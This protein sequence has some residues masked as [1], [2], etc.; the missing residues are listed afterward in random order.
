MRRN[1]ILKVLKRYK[2]VNADRYCI[3]KLGL[4]GSSARDEFRAGSDID[5]VVILDSPN[6]LNLIGIKQDLEEKFQ[7]HVDIVRY[8]DKMNPFLK[9]RIEQDAIYV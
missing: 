9:K 7:Q 4:F 6:M 3:L 1:D 2:E 5:V 8:R